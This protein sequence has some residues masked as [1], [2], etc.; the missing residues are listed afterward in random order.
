MEIMWDLIFLLV[1]L[2]LCVALMVYHSKLNRLFRAIRRGEK[3]LADYDLHGT[4][5]GIGPYAIREEQWRDSGLPGSWQDCVR[6][7]YARRVLIA[8]WTRHCPKALENRN[9]EVLA[10]VHC[11][12][13]RGY[14]DRNAGNYWSHVRHEL[15][16]MDAFIV[17]ESL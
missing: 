12:G 16:L 11:G 17:F 15:L 7:S 10:R 1:M 6:P 3:K 4:S 8:Y 9:F 2:G 5:R 14:M 13:P